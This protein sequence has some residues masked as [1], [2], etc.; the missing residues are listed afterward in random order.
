MHIPIVRPELERHSLSAYTCS[1][2]SLQFTAVAN[3]ILKKTLGRRTIEC[4]VL[5]YG[6]QRYSCG[7]YVVDQV[8][9]YSG[10]VST[11]SWDFSGFHWPQLYTDTAQAV[12]CKRKGSIPV[13]VLI[14]VC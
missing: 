7:V 10:H 14:Y 11:N 3:E 2:D 4:H 12:L 8:R 13:V 1:M 6:K 9:D 5:M